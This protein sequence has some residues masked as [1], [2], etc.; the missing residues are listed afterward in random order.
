MRNEEAVW[1]YF[2]E[3]LGIHTI[4]EVIEFDKKLVLDVGILGCSK[5]EIESLMKDR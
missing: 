5:E 2:N 1:K 3:E 4:E